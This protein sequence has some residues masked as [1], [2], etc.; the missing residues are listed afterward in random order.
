M[1]LAYCY[2]V[3]LLGKVKRLY[4]SVL[5]SLIENLCRFYNQKEIIK[6][7]EWAGEAGQTGSRLSL[8]P[9]MAPRVLLL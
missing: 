1:F 3:G 6:A 7:Y 5:F 9:V 2:R 8:H 4:P